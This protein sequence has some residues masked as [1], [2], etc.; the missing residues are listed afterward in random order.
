M[1][2]KTQNDYMENVFAQ[3]QKISKLCVKIS[4]HLCIKIKFHRHEDQYDALIIQQFS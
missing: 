1:K 2:K 4:S 3:L